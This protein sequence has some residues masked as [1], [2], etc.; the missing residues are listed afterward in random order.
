MDKDLYAVLGVSPQAGADEIKRAYRKLAM[1]YH[2]DRNPGNPKAEEKFKEIQRAYDTLSDLSKRMQYDASFRRHEE[3]GRQEEAFRREQARREQFYR[4]QMRREQALRQAFERQASRSCHTY[5]P[6][7]G[8]SGRNYVLAA[9]ILF[10][11]GAI[12]LF[13]PIVGVI[14]AYMKRNSLDS[15]VYAAHTEY[16]IK[17][18][19]RTFWRTFWLYILGALTALLGIGVLIIIATN[20]WYFYRI[21]VGFIRFNGGRAVAPEKWI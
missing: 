12:M 9:Y 1:K 4:E 13:M 14:L 21:I 18:F 11:L 7:G 10:G 19:W 8:G 16:L 3:R 5:E 6:S 15:I 20:V 17:T 2:P